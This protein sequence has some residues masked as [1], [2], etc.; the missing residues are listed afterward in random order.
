MRMG[1]D[2][3]FDR[4]VRDAADARKHCAP[5]GRMLA[6][7]DHQHAGIGHQECGIGGR[8]VVEEVQIGRHLLEHGRH[9]LALLGRR[10][11]F[12]MSGPSGLRE[13]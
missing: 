9:D 1:V 4:L 10:D 8:I 5:I 3:P 2:H 13:P 11:T 7:V 6:G 12:Q